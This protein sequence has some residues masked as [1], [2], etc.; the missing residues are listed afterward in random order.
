MLAYPLFAP[1]GPV[2]PKALALTRLPND[3]SLLSELSSAFRFLGGTSDPPKDV[4][5]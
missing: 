4:Y 3:I 1:F 2:P 5:I